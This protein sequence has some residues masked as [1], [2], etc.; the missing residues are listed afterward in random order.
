MHVLENLGIEFLSASALETLARAGA[1]VD[2][3]TQM[4]RLDRGLVL[5]AVA[6]AP[7][8]EIT[9][10]EAAIAAATSSMNSTSRTGPLSPVATSSRS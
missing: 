2:L 7:A 5:E 4:V 9:R 8:R 10:W 6:R 1:E 3:D